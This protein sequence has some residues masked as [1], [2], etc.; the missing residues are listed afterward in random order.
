MKQIIPFS[1]D[2]VFKTNIA[3]ITSISLEH[4]EKIS[5]G[6]VSG[7]FIV[8][9]DYKIHNDT[10]E[11]ELFKYKLPFTA[12][13]PDNVVTETISIDVKNFTY[14]TVEDDVLRVNID[15]VIEG[16][17]QEEEKRIEDLPVKVEE[18]AN[19]EVANEL[20]FFLDDKI[21]SNISNA[22]ESEVLKEDENIKEEIETL[23]EIPER[24]E[25]EVL[26]TKVEKII[27]DEVLP[28]K[29]EILKEELEEGEEE[30]K[31]N[32]E[33]KIKE[34]EEKVEEKVDDEVKKEEEIYSK[35]VI[36]NH[37]NKLENERDLKKDEKIDEENKIEESPKEDSNERLDVEKD[38]EELKIMNSKEERSEER[39]VGKECL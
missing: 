38:S 3:S 4:E 11:K 7:D 13:I 17:E 10:T 5:D 39:R 22:R 33:D 37:D 25:D 31:V 16:E 36:N 2:I 34:L 12:L 28:L 19:P 24:K 32:D 29:K 26:K 21:L 14:D 27:L 6:E 30:R 35:N 18:G 23:E 20:N 15:F 1:K 9:G 8:F